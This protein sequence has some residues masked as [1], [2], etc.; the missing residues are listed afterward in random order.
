MAMG[1]SMGI[2][3]PSGVLISSGGPIDDLLASLRA[4]STYFE[5]EACTRATLQKFEAIS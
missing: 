3:I 4:R 2:G 1:I 5:N